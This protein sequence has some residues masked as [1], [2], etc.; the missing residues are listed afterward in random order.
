MPCHG[1]PG[2][3][4]ANDDDPRPRRKGSAHATTLPASC[5]VESPRTEVEPG[6]EVF[7]GISPTPGWSPRL[8][9]C[10]RRVPL[11]GRKHAAPPAVGDRMAA[12]SWRGSMPQAAGSRF[13][14]MAGGRGILAL[15]VTQPGPGRPRHVFAGRRHPACNPDRPL[16][17]LPRV[18][19]GRR[20]THDNPR[21]P[22]DN[23]TLPPRN[24]NPGRKTALVPGRAPGACSAVMESSVHRDAPVFI[25]PK[26]QRA[27]PPTRDARARILRSRCMDGCAPGN[28]NPQVRPTRVS[29]ASRA[30]G[31]SNGRP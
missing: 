30:A 4:A 3:A 5:R 15:D 21:S 27:P 11:R 10:W 13:P 26:N 29:R 12:A 16:Q 24:P 23:A 14:F 25:P 2:H 19:H 1:C 9:P 17:P 7:V 31:P 20:S 22:A 18:P 8:G 6:T 28:P